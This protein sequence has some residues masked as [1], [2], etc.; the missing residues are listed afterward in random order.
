ME[1]LH[2]KQDRYLISI[3]KFGE[4]FQCTITVDYEHSGNP[5]RE[6]Y[7]RF[8]LS[9]SI[10][11]AKTKA[12]DWIDEYTFGDKPEAEDMIARNMELYPSI[13]RNKME[14]LQ[15][16]MLSSPGNGYYWLDGRVIS[17]EAE[18]EE[19]PDDDSI[20][21]GLSKLE[22]KLLTLL[23]DDTS[24]VSDEDK[25]NIQAVLDMLQKPSGPP[26][27]SEYDEPGEN[28]LVFV[29]PPDITPDWYDICEEIEKQFRIQ[30]EEDVADK[31]RKGL[32]ASTQ[33][34]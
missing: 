16:M 34:L 17:H 25:A 1:R 20:M 30:G 12:L 13:Y 9:D 19:I 2:F 3:W 14:C 10:E 26:P 31:I 23:D 6:P 33:H 5:F 8:D 27:R 11:E 28:A 18:P 22:S 24:L 21:S 4:R 32:D 29:I 15:H 7:I